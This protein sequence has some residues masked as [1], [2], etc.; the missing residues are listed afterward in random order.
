M[1]LRAEAA[2]AEV[3]RLKEELAAA[4]ATLDD[5]AQ[6]NMVRALAAEAEVERLT[7]ALAWEKKHRV[8]A[9]EAAQFE[10]DLNTKAAIEITG[11]KEAL[12]LANEDAEQ[13][14]AVVESIH[15]VE[16]CTCFYRCKVIAAK[17]PA[18]AAHE[19]RVKA[20]EVKG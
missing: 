14:A 12:R 8:I 1:T 18:L 6:Q 13:L 20:E 17:G 15:D 10:C 2:E 5:E 19:A 7:E 3:A 4:I 11:L 16:Y 9:A